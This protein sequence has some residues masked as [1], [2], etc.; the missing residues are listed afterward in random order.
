MQMMQEEP[1]K[2]GKDI[3]Q[4]LKELDELL[5]KM[6]DVTLVPRFSDIFPR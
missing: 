3:E 1:K 2:K 5:L 6:Q 4:E